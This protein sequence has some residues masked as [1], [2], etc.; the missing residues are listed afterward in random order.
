MGFDVVSSINRYELH[1]SAAYLLLIVFNDT[2]SRTNF[3]LNIRVIARYIFYNATN[4]LQFMNKLLVKDELFKLF[5]DS[6]P[7]LGVRHVRLN[8]FIFM[9]LA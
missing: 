3:T 2:T 6:M 9:L 4:L 1:D 7:L 5:E 8:I